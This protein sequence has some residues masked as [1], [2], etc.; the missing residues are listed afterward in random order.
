MTGGSCLQNTVATDT[1]RNSWSPTSIFALNT[2]SRAGLVS[3]MCG[4]RQLL[5]QGYHRA[6]I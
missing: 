1:F 3:G 6:D 2:S 5:Q 4:Q